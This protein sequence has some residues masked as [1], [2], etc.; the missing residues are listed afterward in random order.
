MN[1]IPSNRIHFLILGDILRICTEFVLLQDIRNFAGRLGVD[2]VGIEDMDQG[3][4][5]EASAEDPA[6]YQ[7]IV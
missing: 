4:V 6:D 1:R 3:S 7:A 5:P 2:I